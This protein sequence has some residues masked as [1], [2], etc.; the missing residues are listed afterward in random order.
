MSQRIF[1]DLIPVG[2]TKEL[3]REKP[4]FTMLDLMERYGIKTRKVKGGTGKGSRTP[5]CRDCN[6]HGR[7]KGNPETSTYFVDK[8]PMAESWAKLTHQEY[9]WD[10]EQM[11]FMCF[12]HYMTFIFSDASETLELVHDYFTNGDP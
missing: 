1:P 5:S 6:K 8:N 9:K 3:D 4:R 12:I 2:F 11:E 7:L 10:A